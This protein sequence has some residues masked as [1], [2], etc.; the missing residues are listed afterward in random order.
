M[1]LP[2]S[3]I[4][5]LV[6]PPTAYV[7]LVGRA[8]INLLTYRAVEVEIEILHEEYAP[9]E[10]ISVT[11]RA[12]L[13]VPVIGIKVDFEGKVWNNAAY[14][15]AINVYLNPQDASAPPG[16]RYKGWLATCNYAASWPL[17]PA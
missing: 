11:L 4:F 3:R 7:R 9:A 12:K 2:E 14:S 10:E 17:R 15:V 8:N 16:N 6:E 5:V 1:A 13:D